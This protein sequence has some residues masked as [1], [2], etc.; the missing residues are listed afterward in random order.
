MVTET[1]TQ[2]LG[3]RRA[4]A[5]TTVPLPTPEG[6]DSTVSRAGVGDVET[7]AVTCLGPAAEL[8]DERGALLGAKAAHP[9]GG[10]DAEPLHDLRGAHL[11][12]ARQ[13]LQ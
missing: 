7:G 10:G 2:R 5:A 6:P 12:N 3:L 4:S 13:R 9:P 8:G 1:E 11:A